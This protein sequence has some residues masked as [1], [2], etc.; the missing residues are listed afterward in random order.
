[1]QNSLLPAEELSFVSR[2]VMHCGQPMR[3]RYSRTTWEGKPDQGSEITETVR[4]CESCGASLS[5]T[6]RVPS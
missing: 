6:L 3:Y 2:E 4:E 5:T 1:M